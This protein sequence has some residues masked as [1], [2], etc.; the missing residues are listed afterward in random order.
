MKKGVLKSHELSA[1]NQT[2]RNPA[3]KLGC[4]TSALV[5]VAS[6]LGTGC[7]PIHQQSVEGRFLGL[8]AAV[9][10][11]PPA[12]NSLHVLVVHGMGIHQPGYSDKLA[13]EVSARLNLRK[14]RESSIPGVPLGV[15]REVVYLNAGK[16]VI[17]YEVTWS[18]ATENIKTNTFEPDFRQEGSRQL[19]NHAL[20]KNL[21]DLSLSDA[22]LYAGKYRAQ[23]QRPVRFAL[24]HLQSRLG[25]GDRVAIITFSLGSY[26]LFDTLEQIRSEGRQPMAAGM[27]KI[28]DRTEQI[29]MFANQLPL[30]ELSELTAPEPAAATA[31]SLSAEQVRPNPL[32]AFL[33]QRR[34]QPN[35]TQP[36]IRTAPPPLQVVAF[37]DPNDLLSY[38]L[39]AADVAKNP[40]ANVSLTIAR[41]SYV[42]VVSNPYQAHTGWENDS[43]AISLLIDGYSA[44]R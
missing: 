22:V 29:F 40:C 32:R 37:S 30:L 44:R 2:S 34:L 12:T 21:V 33:E 19:I 9:H 25:A 35:A 28:A 27:Q 11:S 8:R 38:K 43:R 42:G 17:F 4:L 18:M 23:I 7:L 3:F 1:A 16:R 31:L 13:E 14:V 36:E 41:W 20:K 26:V 24:N 6:I 15:L 5:L 39:T 10:S